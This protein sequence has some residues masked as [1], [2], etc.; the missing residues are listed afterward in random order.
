MHWVSGFEPTLFGFDKVTVIR[1]KLIKTKKGETRAKSGDF[2][3]ERLRER[4]S[5][6]GKKERERAS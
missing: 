2:F 5:S 1:V 3:H 6:S 4:D